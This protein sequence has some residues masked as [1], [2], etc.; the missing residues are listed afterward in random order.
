MSIL[1]TGGAGYIGAHVVRSLIER[2]DEVVVVDDL[3]SGDASRLSGADHATIDLAGDDARSALAACIREHGVT[4]IV[5]LAARKQAAESVAVPERYFRDNVGGLAAVVGAAADTGVRRLVF[6]S[7]AAVYG[8]PANPKVDESTPTLPINPYGESKLIGEWLVRDAVVAHG[9][10]A[11]S[12]RYFNVAG[13]GWD[14][15]GDP[16]PLNLVTIAI[17]RVRRG[18]APLVYGDGFETPDGTGIRDY[19]HVLDLAEAHLAALDSLAA[20]QGPARARVY[21]VGT[22]TGASVLEVLARL[23][24]VSGIDLEPRIEPARPGDPAAVVADAS[25]IEAELGWTATRSLDEMVA[26]AWRAAEHRDAQTA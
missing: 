5:H 16:L 12:L 1:I 9:I 2:G 18:L 10:D 26:S 15:L 17:D 22:G 25:R 24:A 8:T 4:G 14:D 11:V 19:I 21:N 20:E 6:S 7:S 23:R 3:S 13:A